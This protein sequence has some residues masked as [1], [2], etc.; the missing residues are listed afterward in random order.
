MAEPKRIVISNHA[1]ARMNLRGATEDQVTETI[2]SERWVP[3]KRGKQR[4]KR[5]FDFNARSPID[6]K[7]YRFKDVEAIFVD[8]PNQIVVV[9]VKVYYSNEEEKG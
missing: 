1:H 4:S 5:R 3:A 2:H 9:T 8:E 7:E 6:K